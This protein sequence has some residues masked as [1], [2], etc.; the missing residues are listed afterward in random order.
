MKVLRVT[1]SKPSIESIDR[2][3]VNQQMLTGLLTTGRLV[4]TFEGRCA[5]YL[6]CAQT[7]STAS[8]T[9]ALSIALIGIGVEVGDEVI[10][11][12]YVC[13]S[14]AD[15]VSSLGA[16][17]VFCDLGDD[18]RMTTSSVAPKITPKTTGIVV[19]HTFGIMSD[20]KEILSLGIPVIEDCCQSFA[21]D[22][23]KY[24]DAAVFSFNATKCLTTGEGG[25]VASSNDLVIHRIRDYLGASSNP[26]RLSDL[27]AA[28]GLSQLARYSEFLMQRQKIASGYFESLPEKLTEKLRTLRDRSIFFRFPLLTNMSFE[29]IQHRYLRYDISVRKGVDRLLHRGSGESDANYPNAVK[30]FNKTVSIPIYPALLED[31]YQKVID[32][33]IEVFS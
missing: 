19:V 29:D 20:V 11:P 10:I 7:F 28:L 24:G 12:T 25:L 9:A 17:P 14:V 33:T 30:C 21:K 27:Q 6:N 32:A 1:H 3:A 2:E 18:W 26:A 5:N 16:H 4:K 13:R 31:E 23:G 22:Y 8:G 15:A